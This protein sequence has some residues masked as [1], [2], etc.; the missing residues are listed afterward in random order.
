MSEHSTKP[1]STVDDE[2]DLGF[3]FKAIG[4]FFKAVLKNLLYVFVFFYK[5]KIALIVL[6]ILG[7]VGGYFWESSKKDVYQNNFIVS[8]N[9]E[10]TDYLYNKIDA[11][12]KKIEL[13]DSVY[14]KTIFKTGHD[15]IRLIEIEPINNI[16]NFISE[17]RTNSDVFELLS[18]DENMEE[19][20][21]EPVNSRNYPYHKV[22]VYAAGENLHQNICKNL[23]DYLNGNS[24]F[25]SV[26]N[27]SLENTEERLR[28][29][30]ESRQQ[31]N[32]IIKNVIENK[33]SVISDGLV[34]IEDNQVLDLLINR[35]TSLMIDDLE[36]MTQQANE[37]NAIEIVDSNYKLTYEKPLLEKDKRFLIPLLLIVFYCLIF[38]LK[39]ITKKSKE[40][41]KQ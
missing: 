23:F 19:F 5:H 21:L 38:F 17:E 12:N 39:F 13:K 24:F 32:E 16:Y 11:L 4:D 28:D 36:L 1:S 31:I 15:S 10:S 29:N 30:K 22:N 40:F 9:Y 6:L 41:L 2:I 14:L 34:S 7:V 37:Q 18:E 35:K 20:V 8:A 25:N 3:I 33:S 27:I 26:K